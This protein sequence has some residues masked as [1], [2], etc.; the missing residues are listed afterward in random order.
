[1]STPPEMRGNPQD[2]PNT[3]EDRAPR[4]D[5]HVGSRHGWMMWL[6]C[7]PMVVFAV[8]LMTT[9]TAGAAAL[10]PAILCVAMMAAMM[11]M[12]GRSGGH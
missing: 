3:Q 2:P 8:V 9:T 6:M 12:H 5:R 10:V 7:V 1:M 4:H 11:S